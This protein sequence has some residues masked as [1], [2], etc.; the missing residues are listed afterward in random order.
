MG[1][2]QQLNNHGITVIMVT[3]EADIASYARRNVM[4]RDGVVK[5][6]RV[7]TQRFIATDEMAKLGSAE[8]EAGETQS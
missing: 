6:D 8:P 5:T 3:H 2:F 4:M 1:I 7:V